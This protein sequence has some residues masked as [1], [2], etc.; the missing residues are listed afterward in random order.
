MRRMGIEETNA[1]KRSCFAST[2]VATLDPEEARESCPRE[3]W[4]RAIVGLPR[5]GGAYWSESGITGQLPPSVVRIS[6]D[7]VVQKSPGG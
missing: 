7:Y 4:I 5:P 1:L 2:L 6:A 3:T